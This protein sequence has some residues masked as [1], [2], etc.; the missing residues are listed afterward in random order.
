MK[1]IFTSFA[2]KSYNKNLNYLEENWNVNIVQDF[3][4]EVERTINI[5]RNYLYYIYPYLRS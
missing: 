4:L 5:I 2:K 3:I 1:V